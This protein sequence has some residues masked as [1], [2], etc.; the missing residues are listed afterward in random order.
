[1][2]RV[3]VGSAVT[4]VPSAIVVTLRHV[5][6]DTNIYVND[7]SNLAVGTRALGG[8]VLRHVYSVEGQ[9]DGVVSL[10]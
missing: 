8:V 5:S 2:I 4:V 7:G 10:A 1:M 6:S 3:R 9:E